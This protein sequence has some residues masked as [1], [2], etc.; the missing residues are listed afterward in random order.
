MGWGGTRKGAGR[1]PKH[2]GA[3]EA[4][5]DAQQD[6]APKGLNVPQGKEPL[7]F[8]RAVMDDPLADP[9]LRVRAAIA[10]AQYVHAKKGEGGKKDERQA[11]AEKAGKGRFAPS[12]PPKLAVVAGGK[13]TA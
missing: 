10:A 5:E 9:K 1:K 12:A 13:S 11:A 4:P 2:D 7:E 3:P 6:D 8:L